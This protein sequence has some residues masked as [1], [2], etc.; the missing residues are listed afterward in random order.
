MDEE[1]NKKYHFFLDHP[2]AYWLEYGHH[3]VMRYAS[4][5]DVRGVLL[6]LLVLVSFFAYG[7][8]HTRYTTAVR[9][10]RKAAEKNLGSKS[11]GNA[12]TMQLRREAEALLAE[13]KGETQGGKKNGVGSKAGSKVVKQSRKEKEAELAEVIAE[14]SLEVEIK[15]SCRK[16]TWRDQPVVLLAMLPVHTATYLWHKFQLVASKLTKREVTASEREYW[17]RRSVGSSTWDDLDAETRAA[18]KEG[19]AWR[20]GEAMEDWKEAHLYGGGAT[21]SSKGLRKRNKVASGSM[22]KG[23]LGEGPEVEY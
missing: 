4:A 9:Y 22:M 21:S 10:L 23:V 7:I 15:G 3:W 18:A 16:P 11:G 12:A 1:L 17:A 8:Q 20:G 13:R 5:S 2:D 19:D 14:L 6:G